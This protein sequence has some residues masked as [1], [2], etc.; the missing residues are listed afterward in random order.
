MRWSRAAM[1]PTRSRRRRAGWPTLGVAFHLA[2]DAGQI[3]EDGHDQQ[4]AVLVDGGYGAAVVVGELLV[5][6][7][8]MVERR[9]QVGV[10]VRMR[11]CLDVPTQFAKLA[12]Q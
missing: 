8:G 3:L 9:R 1:S 7:V 10:L 11:V 4:L 5:V 2:D 12:H 6:G